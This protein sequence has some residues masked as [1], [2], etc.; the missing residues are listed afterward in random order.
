MSFFA[1]ASRRSGLNG[2]RIQALAPSCFARCTISGWPS[3]VSIT[4]GADDWTCWR[5]SLPFIRG[6]LTSHTI[7]DTSP[8]VF[9]RS[10]AWAPSAAEPQEAGTLHATSV[11][12]FDPPEARRPHRHLDARGRRIPRDLSVIATDRRDAEQP[13]PPR[14][15]VRIGPSA[16]G[17][18]HDNVQ[19]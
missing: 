3:V 14:R 5:N 13:P 10:S 15:D 8:W 11:F 16:A 2:F 1:A 9:S 6:V 19:R 12:S 18:L 7:S 17:D 4:T